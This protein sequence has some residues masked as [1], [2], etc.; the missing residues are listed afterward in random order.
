MMKRRASF[1]DRLGWSIIVF[2]L[3]F[4]ITSLLT[5]LWVLYPAA[6]IHPW[7]GRVAVF[8]VLVSIIWQWWEIR[9]APQPRIELAMSGSPNGD[10]DGKTER[11]NGEPG[12]RNYDKVRA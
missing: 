2:D 9:H 1:V 7:V 4:G 12:R 10:W 6:E 5:V 11:R 3:V 8:T